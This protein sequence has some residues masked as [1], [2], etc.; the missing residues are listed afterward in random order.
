MLLALIHLA[1]IPTN[2][3]T[4]LAKTKAEASIDVNSKLTY[5][6]KDMLDTFS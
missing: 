2:I 1:Q 4:G 5:L 3:Q 6:A